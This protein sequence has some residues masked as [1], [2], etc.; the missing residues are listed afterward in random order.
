MKSTKIFIILLAFGLFS[1]TCNAQ[2]FKKLKKRVENSVE[3]TIQ[4][5][6]ADKASKETGKAMDQ[7]LEP[8]ASGNQDSKTST[9]PFALGGSTANLPETYTFQWV[10]RLKMETQ[11][12]RDNME[13]E[14]YL[15][16]DAPYWGAQFY[17]KGQQEAM[18]MVMVYDGQTETTAMFMDQNGQKIV[19]TTKLPKQIADGAMEDMEGGEYTITK[20]GGKTVLGYPC[21]GFIMEN[22]RYKTTVYV[23]FDAEVS[24]ADI[25]GKSDKLPKNFNPEWLRKD[26]KDGLMME[27]HMKDK[28]ASKNDVSM[29]CIKLQKQPFSIITGEYQS[30]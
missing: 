28:K 22:D 20:I 9:I 14:Y 3:N 12:E 23:T 1:Q 26:G 27:M 4:R 17:G 8:D 25:Y 2:F 19:T 13:I 11:K 10:Y 6:T 7:V 24:F 5:K 15:K 30:F 18:N 29:N 16:E 21:D